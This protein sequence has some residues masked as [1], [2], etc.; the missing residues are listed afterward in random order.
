MRLPIVNNTN[1]HPISQCLQNRLSQI[2]GQIFAVDGE[3]VPVFNPLVGVNPKLGL[4]KLETP[5]Y[6]IF[7]YLEP[8]RR[9]SRV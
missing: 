6:G 4:N 5:F 9:N 1:L 3:R 7:R 2:I 8:F